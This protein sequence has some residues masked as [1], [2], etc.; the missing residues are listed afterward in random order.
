MKKAKTIFFFS[1][2]D[3]WV[4]CLVI[5]I[6]C[7]ACILLGQISDSDH[8][9]PLIFV[10]SVML[11]SRLTNGYFYGIVASI[12]SVFFVNYVFTYPFF[13]FNFTIAGYP[14][15]FLSMLGVSLVI[16]TLTTQIRQQELIR[17]EGEKEAMRANLL[18]AI[19]HDLRTPLTSI[20]GAMAAVSENMEHLAVKEQ[21]KLLNEAQKDAS[22]LVQMV[23]NLLSITRIDGVVQIDKREEAAEEIVAE[24]V[25]KVRKQYPDIPIWVS[26]P[27]TLLLVP[28]DGILIQQV[29]INLLYNAI[30]HGESLTE[31][32]ISVSQTEDVARFSI[33]DNGIGFPKE[34]LA[35][36]WAENYH[37]SKKVKLEEGGLRSGIGL[38]LCQAII[39]AHKGTI[40]A[41]N[42]DLGGACVTFELPLAK[43][44][45]K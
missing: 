10:L 31:I 20:I 1:A 7:I 6:A 15:T 23:E 4:S 29:L 26:V 9:V 38:S 39:S 43:E 11:V 8:H 41:K 17:L 33:W 30:L 28:M 27:D 45:R 16:S 25:M 40:F 34:N 35:H 3:T 37:I 22:W 2:K 12:F 19:S 21:Q 24:S 14:I 5:F 32:N 36:L 18:R 42:H 44:E 13:A